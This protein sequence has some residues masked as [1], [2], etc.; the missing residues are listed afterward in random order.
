LPC[1]VVDRGEAAEV[2]RIVTAERDS[3]GVV[4]QEVQAI[5][6][7]RQHRVGYCGRSVRRGQVCG[8]HD[9]GDF[10]QFGG[11]GARDSEYVDSLG[12]EPAGCRQADAPRCSGDDREP[13]GQLQV[14]DRLLAPC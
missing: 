11:G 6:R 14:H 8:H 10:L 4:H 13:P 12:G 1:V 2:G 3:A 9:V 5:R 7:P